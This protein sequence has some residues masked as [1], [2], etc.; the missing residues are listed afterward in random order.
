MPRPQPTV[1]W[2]QVSFPEL[3]TRI[4]GGTL[5][6]VDDLV[7]QLDAAD[8]DS[9]PFRIT[10]N[11]VNYEVPLELIREYFLD[12]ARPARNLTVKEELEFLRAR[13]KEL[14]A[15][16][17]EAGLDDGR[18]GLKA[19]PSFQTPFKQRPSTAHASPVPDSPPGFRPNEK[20]QTVAEIQAD[21]AAELRG[22]KPLT[23]EDPRVQGADKPL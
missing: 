19:H 3:V 14:E 17:A 9:S 2:N 21:L 1:V 13:V 11:E 8:K 22:K 6:T 16:L 7:K 4:Q 23:A 15:R 12:H 18:E 5:F 20:K 10:H